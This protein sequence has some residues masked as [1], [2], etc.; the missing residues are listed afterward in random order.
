M[1]DAKCDG[2]EVSSLQVK[3][4]TGA[5]TWHARS[6]EV[7]ATYTAVNYGGLEGAGRFFFSLFLRVGEFTHGSCLYVSADQW[8]G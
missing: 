8:I 3:R 7:Q 2:R 6:G 1:D 4:G 5:G